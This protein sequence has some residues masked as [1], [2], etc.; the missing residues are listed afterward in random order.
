MASLSVSDK[1]NIS[2]KKAGTMVEIFPLPLQVQVPLSLPPR[3][4]PWGGGGGSG[5][6]V[7]MSSLALQLL[8]SAML[9]RWAVTLYPGLQ[10]PPCGATLVSSGN[11]FP[12]LAF[13]SVQVGK[14]PDCR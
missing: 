1:E 6:P 10:H 3:S 2:F 12:V 9:T 14:A 7:L 13:S 11:G 8:V 4:V 5:G